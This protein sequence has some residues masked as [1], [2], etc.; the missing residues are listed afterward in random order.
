MRKFTLSTLLLSFAATLG[1]SGP[2]F[3]D[4]AFSLYDTPKYP[5]GF[6]HFDYF[7]PDA[8]KRGTLYLAN[9]DRRTS[10][11]KFNPFSLKG[12]A[13]AGV[14]TLMFETL[15]VGSSDEVA[16]MY[17]LLADDMTLAP[18][19]M[20]MTFHLNPKARSTTVTRSPRP[21]SN[22]PT[23]RC[24]PKARRNSSR[25]SPTSNNAWWSMRRPCASNS[26]PGT[27]SCR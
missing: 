12:V 6:T 23:T 14:S 4:H 21:T 3:A 2:A 15:A 7:N 17:G 9:P 16:T 11:D 1:F 26:R 20:A 8:P 13:A 5:A 19:R 18:D 25:C 27:T 24:W 22:I 10:F